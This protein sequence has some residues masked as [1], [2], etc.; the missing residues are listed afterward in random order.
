MDAEAAARAWSEAWRRGWV[1]KDPD[2]VAERYAPG[3]VFRSHPFR[4]PWVGTEGARTYARR[5]LEGEDEIEAWFGD[6]VVSGDRAAVEYWATLLEDGERV[7]IAGASILRF[8][9]D[10]RV[11]EHRDYWTL[12]HGTHPPPDGWGR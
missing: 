7:T 9:A 11:I 8:D 6:P 5:A 3:A 4:E 12:D 1:T 2:L 10:G